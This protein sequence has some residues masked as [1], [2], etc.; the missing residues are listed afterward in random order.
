VL[1]FLGLYY[2]REWG[3]AHL[4]LK[5]RPSTAMV[6]RAPTGEGDRSPL[7]E[8]RAEEEAYRDVVERQGGSSRSVALPFLPAR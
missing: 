7:P 8:E 3:E 2:D 5:R 1:P 4:F 6:F